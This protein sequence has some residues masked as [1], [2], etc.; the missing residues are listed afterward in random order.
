MFV[1]LD[2]V[3]NHTSWGNDLIKTHPEFYKKDKEG[4]IVQAGPWT[5]VA[6]LDH[7]NRAVWDYMLAARKYWITEFGV[8]GFREDVAGALPKE[9][10]QWLRPAECHQAGLDARRSRDAGAASSVRPDL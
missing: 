4:H 6:Q 7:S 8:D 3:P 5:D 9:Y 2:W 10:W 1:M